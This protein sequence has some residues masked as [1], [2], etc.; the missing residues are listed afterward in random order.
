M[1]AP[2]IEVSW[3]AL[4][5]KAALLPKVKLDKPTNLIGRETIESMYSGTIYGFANL[6]DGLLRRIKQSLDKEMR[7]VATGGQAQ[8]LTDYCELIDEVNPNLIL[9]G[10]EMLARQ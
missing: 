10:L 7:V 1:I 6:C 5:Q 4:T 3:E 9:E 2:G 8:L